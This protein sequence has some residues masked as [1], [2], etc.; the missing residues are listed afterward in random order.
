MTEAR[1]TDPTCSTRLQ[2]VIVYTLNMTMR[3]LVLGQI[4]HVV[5]AMENESWPTIPT[6]F[7]S[8]GHSKHDY[9]AR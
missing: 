3:Q 6:G 5:Q 2:V 4:R 8:K 9:T 1:Q 7:L